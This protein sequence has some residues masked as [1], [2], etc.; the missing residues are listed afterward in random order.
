MSLSKFKRNIYCSI[1][2]MMLKDY[3]NGKLSLTGK[4]KSQVE[5]LIRKVKCKYI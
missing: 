5:S 2:E 4:Q 3:N 1:L